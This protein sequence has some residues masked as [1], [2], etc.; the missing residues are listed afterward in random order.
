MLTEA[1]FAANQLNIKVVTLDSDTW[2]NCQIRY[3]LEI[4]NAHEQLKV[5]HSMQRDR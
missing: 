1:A 5:E 4:L 2:G 3:E